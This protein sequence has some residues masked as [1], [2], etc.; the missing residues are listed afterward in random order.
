MTSE[1]YTGTDNVAIC[2]TIHDGETIRSAIYQSNVAS[3]M[4]WLMLY[5][6]NGMRPVDINLGGELFMLRDCKPQYDMQA[7]LSGMT[8]VMLRI[9]R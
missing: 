3:A 2:A 9:K 7:R 4:S 8:V 6:T 5:I 1:N